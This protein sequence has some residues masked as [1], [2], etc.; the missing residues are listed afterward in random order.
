MPCTRSRPNGWPRRWRGWGNV[1]LSRLIAA[2]ALLLPSALLARTDE[3][4]IIV[5]GVVDG[6][7]GGG[8]FQAQGE[9]TWTSSVNFVVWREGGPDGN[10][11][12]RTDPLRVEIPDQQRSDLAK[13]E[14]VFPPRTLV[15]IAIRAPV[16]EEQHRA[17]AV[18]SEPL[19]RPSDTALLAA[20]D[21][22][23]NPAPISDPDLGKFDADR[24]FPQ[25]F[26]QKRDWLGRKIDVVLTLDYSGPPEPDAP[27]QA[28]A[29]LRNAWEKREEW[30][31]RAREAIAADY[32]ETWTE[33][34][35]DENQPRLARETFKSRFLLEEASFAPNGSI[36][37]SF[38]D[39]NLF[40]GHGMTVSYDPEAGA[41]HA[42]MFG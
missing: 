8:G 37:F 18:L 9:T 26:R 17:R 20:A 2:L 41:L 12:I 7:G 25:W 13:W 3:K 29:N 24:T 30:D 38:S 22:L 5:T 11:P 1:V 39:G 36:I 21:A 16:R 31:A 34:W 15:R 28:L 23:L 19:P 33:N 32:Y 42:E 6:V 14:A 40:L 35:R 4:V 27:A 10:G